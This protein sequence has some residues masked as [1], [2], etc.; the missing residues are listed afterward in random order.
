MTD[1]LNDGTVATVTCPAGS[2]P[3]GGSLTCGY[4]ATPGGA[5][6][7]LNTATVS[8]SFG[9]IVATAPWRSSPRWSVTR[10]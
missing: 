6:A 8:T 10:R 9:D 7:T 2:V 1:V 3:A 5:T 4:V